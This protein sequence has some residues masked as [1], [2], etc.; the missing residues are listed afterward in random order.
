MPWE[1]IPYSCTGDLGWVGLGSW[2][3]RSFQTKPGKREGRIA[4]QLQ[5]FLV[6]IHSSPGCPLPRPQDN[7]LT[8][9]TGGCW[10]LPLPLNVNQMGLCSSSRATILYSLVASSMSTNRVKG[11]LSE[12]RP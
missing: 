5:A 1:P 11:P 3:W 8:N 7:F 4:F 6:L 9:T 10:P 2:Q 12:L